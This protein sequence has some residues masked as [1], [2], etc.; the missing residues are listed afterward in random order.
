MTADEISSFEF[1][2]T[3][4]GKGVDKRLSSTLGI[5]RDADDL[6]PSLASTN[7]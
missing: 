3:T 1:K 5:T 7:R 2:R 6:L 4:L